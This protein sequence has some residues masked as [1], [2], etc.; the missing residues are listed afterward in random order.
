MIAREKFK[1]GD[2]VRLTERAKQQKVRCF[3]G[4]RGC[5]GQQVQTGVVTGFKGRSSDLN[6]CVVKVLPDGAKTSK[7]YHM[8]FWELEGEE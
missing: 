4:G 5:R 7:S 8:D 2:H 3:N 1:I 6:E